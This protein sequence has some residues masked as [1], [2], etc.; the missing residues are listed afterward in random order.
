MNPVVRVCGTTI[1]RC[2]RPEGKYVG[3]V[4]R[5]RKHEYTGLPGRAVSRVL[6]FV[7]ADKYCA[8]APS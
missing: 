5:C 1:T 2:V 3:P 4:T 6:G 8:Y 7:T